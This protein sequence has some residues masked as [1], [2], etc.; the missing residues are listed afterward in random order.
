MDSVLE[1]P[2]DV[3]DDITGLLYLGQLTKEVHWGGHTFLL[4]TL[5]MQE[6][7]AIGLLTKEYES[8]FALGRAI[9]AA[10]VG[11]ALEE[12]DGVEF[13]AALGPDVLSRVKSKYDHVRQWFWPVIEK[14]YQE[15]LDL[16][17]K[18]IEAFE[19]FEG[20]S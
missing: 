19:A 10:T 14:L 20:N 17:K 15:Y 18:Q 13:V 8:T 11:A 12:L 6:E 4:R 7:L 3:A 1:F 2:P 16:Q 5:R 9:A